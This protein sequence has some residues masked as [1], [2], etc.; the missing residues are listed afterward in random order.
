[1]QVVFKVVA[2]VIILESSTR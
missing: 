1:M 2:S